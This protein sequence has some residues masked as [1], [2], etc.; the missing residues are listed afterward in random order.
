MAGAGANFA[1]SPGWL[2]MFND[3]LAGEISWLLPLTLVGLVAGLWA[4]RRLP[5]TSTARAGWLLWGG[6]TL[7][8]AI[9]FSH[10]KGIFHPYYTVVMAPA[11]GAL[12]GAGAVA[13]W[14]L[15]R[16]DKRWAPVLPAAVAGSA[17]W[18]A[19]V[20]DRVPG[21]DSWLAPTVVV[22]GVVSALAILAVLLGLTRH[23]AV[24]L[25]AGLVAGATLLAGPAAYSITTINTAYQGGGI[26]A[27]PSTGAAWAAPAAR[28]APPAGRAG[29]PMP[30]SAVR[31]RASRGP[32]PR[33]GRGQAPPR[34][35]RGRASA[36]PGRGQ[37]RPR[38][39]PPAGR[40]VAPSGRPPPAGAARS[41]ALPAAG[42]GARPAPR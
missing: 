39:G 2:R 8:F 15:G 42:A 21:Y 13:L 28:A 35:G 34:R 41:A 24:A 11:V 4:T 14:K 40:P 36:R 29:A 31:R 20:L 17:I 19:V 26:T 10:A 27:G 33:P 1:G 16:S 7:M 9:L 38:P 32:P 37:G 3:L 6:W 22:A 12:A 25:V 18:A 23:R 30:G 5:R